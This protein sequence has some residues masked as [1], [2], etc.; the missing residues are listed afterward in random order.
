MKRQLFL[1]ICAV[2]IL[3]C[4]GAMRFVSP[5]LAQGEVLGI[6]LLSPSE[7][8]QAQKLLETKNNTNHFVTVP[9][10]YDDLGHKD[11]WQNFLNEAHDAHLTP[12]IRLT[13]RFENGSWVV[14][15]QADIIK[16]VTFLSSLSWK[17]TDLTVILFNEPNHAN[18][19]GGG[20]DPEGYVRIADFATDW[21][22]TE[23]KH[24]IVLPAGLDLSANT[25]PGT[26]EEFTFWKR[27]L[28]DRPEFI[29]KLDGW[30]SHSYPNPGFASDPWKTDKGSL[31]GYQHEL[32]FLSGYTKK[33]L[34]VYITET[35]WNHDQLTNWELA[36]YYTV[37][38]SQIWNNDPRIKAVTPFLLQ[39]AP[40]TF[41]PFSF[42]DAHGNP[43]KS[44][45]VYKSLVLMGQ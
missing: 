36:R 31:R 19:W 17:D 7:L 13:S 29:E 4:M 6:H 35:G 9:L 24:Y 39:G 8:S 30:T 45:D 27:A 33:E 25:S 42:L 40:G 15:N 16:Y 11:R 3:F 2:L 41:A 34:P 14:P 18:E 5:A 38:Y 21:F 44:Y 22:K 23:E 26:M 32:T 37:A 20:V 12:L 10:T 28:A 43:T 1:S